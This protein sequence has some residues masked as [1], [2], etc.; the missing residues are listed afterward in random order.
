MGK[1]SEGPEEQKETSTQPRY[2]YRFEDG[3][4]VVESLRED[5]VINK[6][7]IYQTNFEDFSF[8]LSHERYYKYGFFKFS[9]DALMVYEMLK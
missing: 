9:D 1:T 7:K 5:N 8:A 3:G 6:G 2:E 4:F